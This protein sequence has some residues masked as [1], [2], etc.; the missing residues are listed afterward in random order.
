MKKALGPFIF[1]A[2]SVQL[3]A[4]AVAGERVLTLDPAATEI[5]FS[6][7]ATGHV[8]R[9]SFRLAGGEV[10]FDPATGVVTGE[11]TVDAT[12]AET[13]N[14]KRDRKMH[15]KVLESGKHPLFVFALERFDGRIADAGPSEIEVHGT[16]TVSGKPHPMTL[17]VTVEASGD[18]LSAE[19]AFEI[20]YVEWGMKDPSFLFLRVAK[21][22]EVKVS[23]TGSLS[24]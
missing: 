19:T 12:G 17:A 5:A 11:L 9:G 4:P 24:R 2:A 20:P 10:R 6:L 16:M 23:A 15:E 1:L 7:K 13:G 3:L 21:V 18:E 14:D 22:V 8:V